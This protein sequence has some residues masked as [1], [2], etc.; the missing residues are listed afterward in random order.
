MFKQQNS[1]SN[2]EIHVP[3][4]HGVRLKFV[5]VIGQCGVTSLCSVDTKW[6]TLQKLCGFADC[7]GCECYF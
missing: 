2:H 3:F 6:P 7:L 1:C 4:E 5:D